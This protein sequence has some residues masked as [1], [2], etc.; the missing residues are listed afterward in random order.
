MIKRIRNFDSQDW[1]H[2]RSLTANIFV[3]LLK[4]DWAEAK[5]AA[6]WLRL[7][8]THDSERVDDR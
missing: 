8:F 5:D 6:Y 2:V 3:Q 7:H 1:R 4:G